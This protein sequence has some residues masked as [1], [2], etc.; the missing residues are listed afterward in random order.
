M[1]ARH[2]ASRAR[3]RRSPPPSRTRG[4]PAASSW[5]RERSTTVSPPTRTRRSRRRSRRSSRRSAAPRAPSLSV[6]DGH[7]LEGGHHLMRQ[8]AQGPV[9]QFWR[10][11][12]GGVRLDHDAVE[13][14]LLTE[15]REPVDELGRRA[16]GYP[17]AEELIV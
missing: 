16:E 15:L 13:T 3:W 1:R 14:Q 7:S 6:A 12:S 5:R 10:N 9:R 11:E 4:F 2:G 17:R 8:D